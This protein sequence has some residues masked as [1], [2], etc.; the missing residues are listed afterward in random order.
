MTEWATQEDKKLESHIPRNPHSPPPGQQL[1]IPKGVCWSTSEQALF[2]TDSSA[3]RS[4]GKQGQA[5]WLLQLSLQ[6]A[7]LPTTPGLYA[8]IDLIGQ[9]PFCK[10]FHPSI[11]SPV[12]EKK[13][14]G[15][16]AAVIRRKVQYSSRTL[17]TPIPTAVNSVGIFAAKVQSSE[18]NAFSSAGDA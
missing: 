11:F 3:W 13:R 14:S 6:S 5:A 10:C 2:T 4:D 15:R 1:S 9:N 16:S 7:K 8:G 17:E 12:V 18:G